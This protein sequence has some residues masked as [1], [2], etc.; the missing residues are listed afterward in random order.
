MSWTLCIDLGTSF[1]TAVIA[2]EDGCKFVEVDGGRRMPSVVNVD[3][4][5]R[6]HT[7]RQA[8]AMAALD[9]TGAIRSPKSALAAGEHAVVRSRDVRTVDLVAAVLRR[10]ADEAVRTRSSPPARLVLTHPAG[11]DEGGVR[12]LTAAA[13]AAGLPDPSE[14]YLSEPEAAACWYMHSAGQDIPL[15]SAVAIYD[16]G[17]G[18]F[19]ATVLRRNHD[20][21]FDFAGID[22]EPWLGGQNFDKALERVILDNARH[23]DAGAYTRVFGS[24]WADPADAFAFREDVIRVKEELSTAQFSDVRVR[25]FPA[26]IRVTRG[27]FVEAISPDLERSFDALVRVVETSGIAGSRLAH[28]MLSGGS[29]QIPVISELMT[30][31]FGR[32]PQT[33]SDPKGVVVLGAAAYGQLKLMEQQLHR[34]AAPQQVQVQP[35]AA[36]GRAGT[37]WYEKE[38]AIV[39]I[40]VGAIGV[41]GAI[42]GAIDRHRSTVRLY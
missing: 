36:G 38:A 31:V 7:G 13:L 24:G 29:S 2:D 12:R 11:W 3:Q 42:L 19:D 28:I 15:G 40:G 20:G 35:P 18:T 26:A 21:A 1:T 41:L 32:S 9:P 25:G 6:L 30:Q 37:P 39:G 33:T 5:G 22:G 16:L 27:Q 8:H 17:G 34:P 14:L 10:I 23:I 4:A